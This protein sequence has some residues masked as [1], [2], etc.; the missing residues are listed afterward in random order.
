VL[1]HPPY[2]EEAQDLGET[3]TVVMTVTFDTSGDVARAAVT[4]SS[5]VRL[6]DA[7]TRSF[8][9]AHWHSATLAG[10]TVT[11]PVLYREGE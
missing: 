4:Q 11:Q 7:T 10:Q 3:G 2:P 5:G 1:P 8:I 6:L 9:L